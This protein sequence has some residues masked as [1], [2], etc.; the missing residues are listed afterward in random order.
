MRAC[1]PHITTFANNQEVTW[2]EINAKYPEKA[3]T[4][5][6]YSAFAEALLREM[7][8]QNALVGLIQNLGHRS[9]VLDAPPGARGVPDLLIITKDNRVMFR[10]LKCGTS[11]SKEQDAMISAMKKNGL[12]VDIWTPEDLSGKRVERELNVTPSS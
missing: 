8:F 4:P 11:S 10:E 9:W 1:A 6:Q 2:D 3:Y 7:E 5:P 12:D